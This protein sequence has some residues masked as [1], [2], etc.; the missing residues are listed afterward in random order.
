[1]SGN[2][3][4]KTVLALPL[5]GLISSTFWFI[6]NPW[7]GCDGCLFYFA[8]EMMAAIC[9]WPSWQI[10]NTICR[11]RWI[12]ADA[13]KQGNCVGRVLLVFVKTTS[14]HVKLEWG[15]IGS[16]CERDLF[17]SGN[18]PG[19]CRWMYQLSLF[20]RIRDLSSNA[21]SLH[22]HTSMGQRSDSHPHVTSHY[23]QDVN[24]IMCIWIQMTMAEYRKVAAFRH[25]HQC[26]SSHKPPNQTS[27]SL[28]GGKRWSLNYLIHPTLM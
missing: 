8:Q 7:T 12:L 24:G 17:F 16:S 1:M 20:T 25:T 19:A 27:W 15:I 9:S 5:C 22:A 10:L 18:L 11:C 3:S 6:L 13:A 23:F 28:S 26:L 4:S 2:S 14:A 21:T